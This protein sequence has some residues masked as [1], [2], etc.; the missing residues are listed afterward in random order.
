[1]LSSEMSSKNGYIVQTSTDTRM[2]FAKEPNLDSKKIR[3]VIG[4]YF[5]PFKKGRQAQMTGL[6]SDPQIVFCAQCLQM[7]SAMGESSTIRSALEFYFYRAT[8]EKDPTSLSKVTA[9]N[10]KK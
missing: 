8:D 1:M 10:P 6:R 4:G 3:V 2:F 9:K 5:Y 7:L